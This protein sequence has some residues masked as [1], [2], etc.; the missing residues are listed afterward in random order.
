MDSCCH[1]RFLAGSQWSYPNRDRSL[2]RNSHLSNTHRY[3]STAA[4]CA[5]GQHIAQTAGGYARSSSRSS[6]ERR[7]KECSC[8]RPGQPVEKWIVCGAWRVLAVDIRLG[9]G[10]R[11]GWPKVTSITSSSTRRRRRAPGASKDAGHDVY[12][13]RLEIDDMRE[14]QNLRR[15]DGSAIWRT[16][17]TSGDTMLVWTALGT[18][19]VQRQQ[20]DCCAGRA[21]RSWRLTHGSAAS[22]E[23]R[24]GQPR[25]RR[26]TSR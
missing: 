2:P 18:V 1:S 12:S 23:R 5:V 15:G 3:Q 9:V 4:S 19:A 22:A 10:A 6:L 24:S 14:S 20:R 25:Q 17:L 8:L 16:S 26:S 13:G 7:R 11:Y 21:A